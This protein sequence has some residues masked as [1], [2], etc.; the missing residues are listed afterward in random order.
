[1]SLV[2]LAAFWSPERCRAFIERAEARGIVPAGTDYP[3]HYR[4]NDRQVLDDPE[5][6]RAVFGSLAPHL[7]VW[8]GKRAV[9]VNPRFRLCRYQAGQFFGRHRD[10]V[11][12]ASKTVASRLSLLIYLNDAGEFAG[13]GTRFFATQGQAEPDRIVRAETGTLAFFPHDVWHD[14]EAVTA[15]TKYVLRSDVLYESAAEED[16]HQ[17]YVWQAAVLDHARFV[18][19][20]RDRRILLWQREEGRDEPRLVAGRRPQAQSVTCLAA[21]DESRVVAGSRDRSLALV[22][23]ARPEAEDVLWR[24]AH[25]AAITAVVR[26]DDERFASACAGGVIAVWDLAGTLRSRWRAHEHWI[27]GLAVQGDLLLSIAEDGTLK[28]WSLDGTGVRG[29]WRRDGRKPSALAIAASGEVALG[30]LD[31]GVETGRFQPF[32]QTLD[33]WQ[34]HEAAVRTLVPEGQGGAGAGAWIS[35]GED[36][37]VRRRADGVTTTLATGGDCVRHL[38]MVGERLVVVGYSRMRSIARSTS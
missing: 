25:Q 34:A 38:V 33:R 6:A 23:F 17:G 7:P 36:G 37:A 15:G 3:P 13:G 19:G 4:N 26:L 16:A 11:Y 9:G 5:L 30:F 10:G 2:T 28:A 12:H 8:D 24:G 18:T 27:S 29:S 20:G 22:S 21:L 32:W 14:G 31:G 1:M 35:G